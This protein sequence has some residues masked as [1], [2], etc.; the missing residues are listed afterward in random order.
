M[1][2]YLPNCQ[3]VELNILYTCFTLFV[4]ESEVQKIQT[5]LNI[6]NSLL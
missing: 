2:G 1:L 3:H 4:L 5:L 6:R